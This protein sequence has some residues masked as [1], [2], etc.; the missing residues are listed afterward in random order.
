M[1]DTTDA[2]S[3][4]IRW[5][6]VLAGVALAALI[7]SVMLVR[8]GL[9][10]QGLKIYAVSALCSL[11]L[12]ALLA[13]LFLLPRFAESRGA[14]I[15]RA[16]PA[17]PGAIAM[18]LALQGGSVPAIHDIT[19]D[20]DDP[21]LF[22]AA[23]AVR[24]ANSNSLVIDSEVIDQQL[25][26]YPDLGTFESP[27]SYASTYNLALTT[28]RD[29]D[30][31]IIRED[32]NA[33]YI[34]AVDTTAIMNFKDDVVIRVRT[35]ESGSLVDL[36]SVSRVGISDLGANAARIQRFLSALQSAAQG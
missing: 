25:A 31:E 36:R 24:G 8:S 22:E 11:I 28:A 2:L 18:V 6:G 7:G 12:L 30:W 3:R 27:R 13:V 16:L 35:N 19:T 33:G 34:E 32:P 1:T 9:W 26:A 17:V 20:T 29:M 10:Q 4:W 14:I 5:P 23:P 21:P 15:K